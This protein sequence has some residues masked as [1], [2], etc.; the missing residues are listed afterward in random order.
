MQVSIHSNS[1]S[2]IERP[3]LHYKVHSI[4]FQTDGIAENILPLSD[5]LAG[6]YTLS[7]GVAESECVCYR[8]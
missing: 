1:M 7:L 3:T 8:L 2:P 5:G 6:W 4:P